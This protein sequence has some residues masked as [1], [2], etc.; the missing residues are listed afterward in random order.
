M[1]FALTLEQQH[2]IAIRDVAVAAE[3]RRAVGV[4][5]RAVGLARIR[6]QHELAAALDDLANELEH[7]SYAKP[8]PQTGQL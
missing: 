3:R 8:I 7:P 4:V 5:L 1:K 2:H 6:Q